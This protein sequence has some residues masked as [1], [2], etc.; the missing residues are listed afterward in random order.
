[1]LRNNRLLIIDDDDEA[2][3]KLVPHLKDEGFQVYH[4]STVENSFAILLSRP[5]HLIILDMMME[6]EAGF[7][8]CGRMR[9]KTQ[10]PIIVLAS[11]EDDWDHILSLTLGADDYIPKHVNQKV[12]IARIKALLRRTYQEETNGFSGRFA[13]GRLTID[14]RRREVFFNHTRIE[15]TTF[16]FDLLHFFAAR[17]GTV[18]SRDDIY[19]FFYNSIHNGVCRSVDMYISRIRR[20]LGDD[21]FHPQLLKTVRGAGYLLMD[22]AVTNHDKIAT[23]SI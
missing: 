19:R 23:E 3:E 10:I 17:A 13:I 1:M 12:L 22:C 20:K 6:K 2:V 18:V 16:E 11:R 4:K 7:N 21:P 14:I 15:F 5:P 8:L 9:S